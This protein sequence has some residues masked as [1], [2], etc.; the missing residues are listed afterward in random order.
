MVSESHSRQISQCENYKT[1]GRGRKTRLQVFANLPIYIE[2][3]M[4]STELLLEMFTRFGPKGRMQ[5]KLGDDTYAN[6]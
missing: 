3:K 5:G 2:T 6:T 1:Q 4:C